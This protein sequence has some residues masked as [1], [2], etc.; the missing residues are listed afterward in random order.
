MTIAN[1]P[2]GTVGLCASC[3]YAIRV[4]RHRWYDDEDARWIEADFWDHLV[5]NVFTC[6]TAKPKRSIRE[7]LA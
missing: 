7:V 2:V 5:N 1:D 3:G 6:H 4:N